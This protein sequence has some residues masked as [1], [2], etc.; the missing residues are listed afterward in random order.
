MPSENSR[1]DCIEKHITISAT[2]GIRI[3]P[4]GDV[5]F[6][7]PMFAK[8]VFNEWCAKYRNA[9]NTYF[10]GVGDYL[11]TFSGS[12]RKA[13]AAVHSSSK[14]WMDERVIE[15][16][17]KLAERL[18]FTKGKWLGML[19]GNHNHITADGETITQLLAK[20][21]GA[22][23][24]GV[25]GAIRLLLL[26]KGNTRSVMKYDIWAHHG[27]GGGVLA[28][29]TLNALERWANGLECDLVLMGHDHKCAP[30]KIERLALCGDGDNLRPRSK[31]ITLVRTGGFMKAYEKGKVSYLVERAARPLTLGTAEIR[32]YMRRTEVRTE[33]GKR[34]EN[35]TIITEVTV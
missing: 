31:T 21:L 12:E 30:V 17:D 19:S 10:I 32:L 15:D 29:S 3:V 13:M 14:G 24:L 35:T 11:E 33:N 2:E 16:V 5:H 27:R 20:R 34:T 9:E 18:S 7:A 26:R 23:A 22:P 1:F 25:C 4:I 8:D 6:N 28:G